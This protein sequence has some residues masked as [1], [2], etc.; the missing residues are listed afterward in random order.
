M[1]SFKR[2]ERKKELDE[3]KEKIGIRFCTTQNKMRTV[4]KRKQEY[5]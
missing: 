2:N 5:E 4:N 3:K 1:K